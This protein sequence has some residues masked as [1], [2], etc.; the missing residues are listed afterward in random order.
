MLPSRW[1]RHRQDEILLD[2]DPP[3]YIAE[4]LRR[5]LR[6]DHSLDAGLVAAFKFNSNALSQSFASALARVVR[7][8]DQGGPDHATGLQS[9]S[10]AQESARYF[11]APGALAPSKRRVLW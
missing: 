5:G 10:C 8:S 1:P 9:E 4:N 7:G 11:S 3:K 6:M 2:T